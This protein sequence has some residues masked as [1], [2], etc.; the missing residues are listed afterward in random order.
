MNAMHACGLALA[1]AVAA[2]GCAPEF[3]EPYALAGGNEISADVLNAGREGY[4]HYCY[5]C[6][7]ENGDGRGPAAPYLRPS[8][9]DFTSGVF[10]FAVTSDEYGDQLLPTDEDLKRVV[11]QGLH[12]TAMLAWDIPE[13]VLDAIIQYIKTFSTKWQED[14]PG[15][16]I[17]GSDAKDPWQG[18]QAEAVE[19]GMKVYHAKAQCAS[20]HPSYETKTVITEAFRELS[21]DAPVS[22]RNEMYQPDLKESNHRIREFDREHVA[23]ILPPDFLFN[24]IRS[25]TSVEEIYRVI[26]S[27]VGGTAMPVWKGNDAVSDE[28]LW[29]M[30][31]YVKTLADM[32]DTPNGRELRDRLRSQ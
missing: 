18:K 21:P 11:K 17:L 28:D 10:K 2:A 15:E 14:E 19:R 6:H 4:M 16:P 13:P 12:G 22:F 3:T 9:R 1:W 25:G 29:A 5:A 31:H 30:A 8:P 7:G 20:C 24:A 32:K 27:G 23:K 26:A